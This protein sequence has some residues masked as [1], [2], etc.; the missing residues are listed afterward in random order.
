M[1]LDPGTGSYLFQMLIAGLL[2]GGFVFKDRLAKA[3]GWFKD[4]LK[5]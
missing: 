2:A 5:K 3:A 4:K 1:Y